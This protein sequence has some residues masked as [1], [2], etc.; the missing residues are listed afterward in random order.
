M[1]FTAVEPVESGRSYHVTEVDGRHPEALSDFAGETR[2]TLIKDGMTHRIIGEGAATRDGDGDRVRFHQ[3]D[4]GPDDRD[5]RVSVITDR[6][7]G[8]FQAQPFAAF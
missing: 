2:L 8:R 6:G 7:E 3:K 5:V 4:P 1:T